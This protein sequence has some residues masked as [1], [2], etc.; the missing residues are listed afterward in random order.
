M[1]CRQGMEEFAFALGKPENTSLYAVSN[2]PLHP[3]S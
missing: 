3:N 2:L 1:S